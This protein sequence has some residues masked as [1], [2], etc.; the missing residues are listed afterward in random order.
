MQNLSLRL[1]PCVWG[2]LLHITK[3]KSRCGSIP[4]CM[5]PPTF[6][7]YFAFIAWVYPHVYGATRVLVLTP[8]TELGLSPCVW[9]HLPWGRRS[10]RICGSI[11]MCMGPPFAT[12]KDRNYS[13]VCP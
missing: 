9:G 12:K 13:Q 11:P 3:V 1:S 8:R 7:S 10:R 6:Y 2:H 4:M 5:G